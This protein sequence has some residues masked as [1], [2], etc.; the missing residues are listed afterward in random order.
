MPV[1]AKETRVV[2]AP[3]RTVHRHELPRFRLCLRSGRPRRW[4]PAVATQAVVVDPPPAN[5]GAGMARQLTSAAIRRGPRVPATGEYWMGF[6]IST[7]ALLSAAAGV[8]HLAIVPFGAPALRHFRAGEDLAD[9]DHADQGSSAPGIVSAR[10]AIV[11]FAFAAHAWA[12]AG[13]VRPLSFQSVGYTVITTICV[14][15]GS[16]LL[17]VAEAVLCGSK[18][19]VAGAVDAT[20]LST[21]SCANALR[22]L[23]DLG[24]LGASSSRGHGSARHVIDQDAL[25]AAYVEEADALVRPLS[26]QVGVTWQDT[27]DG[28]VNV[29]RMWDEMG[30]EWVASGQ[31]A[32]AVM[33]PLLTSVRSARVYVAADTIPKLEAAADQARLQPIEGGRLTLAPLPTTTSRTLATTVD[34]VRVAA[35]PRV[36]ADLQ[37]SGVRGEEAAQHLREVVGGG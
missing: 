15:R 31:V 13:N 35:W 25:L 12:Q 18:V 29:G 37:K 33:A 7:G 34:G 5:R 23:T 9:F 1:V 27:V 22:T 30:T 24:L 28:L 11:L 21:G 3:A 36:F 6:A 16:G 19:T 17:A 2:V 32:A 14:I 4:W 10:I 8:L 26:L 20:G